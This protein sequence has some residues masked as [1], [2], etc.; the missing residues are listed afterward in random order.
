MAV[1]RPWFEF[2][3]F[4]HTSTHCKLD[5]SCLERNWLGPWNSWL[6]EHLQKYVQASFRHNL[7][8]C[9]SER[10]L[11]Q[12]SV[13]KWYNIWVPL[14]DCHLSDTI[15]YFSDSNSENWLI[16]HIVWGDIFF[17]RATQ[18]C[19][20]KAEY[21]VG[22]RYNSGIWRSVSKLKENIEALRSI[23]LLDDLAK[24]WQRFVCHLSEGNTRILLQFLPIFYNVNRFCRRFLKIKFDV[25]CSVIDNH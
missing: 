9:C 10:L 13:L 7:Y 25:L 1:N 17:F 8:A 22:K 4:L 15:R 6:G 11:G 19:W 16:S 21:A 3:A 5:H 24:S 18:I 20:G 23:T 12:W 14:S 2:C